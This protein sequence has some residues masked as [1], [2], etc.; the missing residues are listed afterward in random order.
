MKEISEAI[1]AIMFGIGLAVTVFW[2]VEAIGTI[3]GWV[4]GN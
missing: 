3:V 4:R 1:I 2:V